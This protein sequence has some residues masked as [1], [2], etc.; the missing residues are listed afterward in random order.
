MMIGRVSLS[1]LGLTPADIPLPP[2]LDVSGASHLPLLPPNKL[3]AN[4]RYQPRELCFNRLPTLVK[5]IPLHL[6]WAFWAKPFRSSA[7]V[8]WG[9]S[10]CALFIP[11]SAKGFWLGLM[12]GSTHTSPLGRIRTRRH[13]QP[14]RARRSRR[15]AKS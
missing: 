13:F 5:G 8:L 10:T 1:R 3:G 12:K 11:L 9:I 14:F 4:A 6:H 7:D 2:I 15:S